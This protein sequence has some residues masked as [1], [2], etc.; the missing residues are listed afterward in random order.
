MQIV[1]V[2]LGEQRARHLEGNI[3]RTKRIFPDFKVVLIGNTQ[4]TSKIA[5][6][7][8]VS[9]FEYSVSTADNEIFITMN[10]NLNFRKGFWRYSIERFTAL[11]QYHQ[12][13][14]N[15]VIIHLES[16]VLPLSNFPFQYLESLG[17]LAWTRFNNERDVAAIVLLPSASETKWL[18]TEIMTL[19]RNNPELTDMTSLHK[20]SKQNPSRVLMLPTNPEGDSKW[21]GIF[22]AAP[23][24][25]W[26]A[27]RDPRNHI[28]LIRRYLS[29]PESDIDLRNAS[30]SVRNQNLVLTLG[31]FE[32]QVFNLHL[33]SKRQLYFSRFWLFALWIDVL[34]AKYRLLGSYFSLRAFVSIIQDFNNR[35]RTE[36][37]KARIHLILDYLR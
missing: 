20:V 33:H 26:L 35:H 18:S 36:S 6:K 34:T 13:N 14:P 29:L 21:A 23:I 9:Y 30:F 17:K 12:E 16:D 24:G 19:M 32:A 28:G 5:R 2:H 4:Y 8:G 10:K 3:R 15:E 27:G 37:L 1:F 25:M 11:N 31:K 22:D 7:V